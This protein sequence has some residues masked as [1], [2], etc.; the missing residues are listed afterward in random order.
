MSLNNNRQG[1]QEGKAKSNSSNP[2]L[3]FIHNITD[4]TQ[5]RILSLGAVWKCL[6]LDY[7]GLSAVASAYG[8]IWERMLPDL[9]I[10]VYELLEAVLPRSIWIPVDGTFIV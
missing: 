3:S 8:T 7:F 6:C 10:G 4:A 1:N 2:H 9:M 5:A